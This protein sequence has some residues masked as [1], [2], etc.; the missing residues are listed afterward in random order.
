M[1]FE[2]LDEANTRITLQAPSAWMD[3]E[4][5]QLVLTQPQLSWQRAADDVVFHASGEMGA[6]DVQTDESDLPSEFHTL[7]ISGAAQAT[8]GNFSVEAERL[9]FDNPLKIFYIPP[10]IAYEMRR[11]EY[12]SR[13]SRST[14]M[15]FDPIMQRMNSNLEVL[16]ENRDAASALSFDDDGE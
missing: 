15:Y 5:S 3:Y 12:Q 8:S 14:G 7:E 13:G 11:G 16:L 6:F 2:Q 1:R 4:A 9:V 10:G